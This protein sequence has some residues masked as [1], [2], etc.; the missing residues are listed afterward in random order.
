MRNLLRLAERLTALTVIAVFALL[1][2]WLAVFVATF[3]LF[4][5]PVRSQTHGWLGPTPRGARCVVDIGK[6]NEWTCPDHSVF[7]RHRLGCRLW[8]ALYGF[9]PGQHSPAP[10]ARRRG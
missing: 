7:E 10:A 2:Y 3:Q 4:G 1:V 8:L 5:P 6:V 9:A